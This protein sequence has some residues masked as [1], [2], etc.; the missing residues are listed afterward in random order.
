MPQLEHIGIAVNDGGDV[1]RICE[2]LEAGVFKSEAVPAEGVVTHFVSAGGPRLEFLTTTDEA[3]AV[4]RFLAK[5]GPGLHHLAFEVAGIDVLF[6]RLQSSGVELA[7]RAVTD[8]ADGKRVFFVHPRAA[9]G[10]LIE[11]CESARSVLTR[12][13]AVVGGV[14][15]ELGSD[16]RDTGGALVVVAPESDRGDVGRVVRE[17][18][19]NVPIR[20]V[21]YDESKSLDTGGGPS[22]DDLGGPPS[23]VVALGRHSGAFAIA[24]MEYSDVRVALLDPG[25]ETLA[26]VRSTP[27]AEE[28]LLVIC[29]AGVGCGGGDAVASTHWQQATLPFGGHLL[30]HELAPLVLPIIRRFFSLDREARPAVVVGKQP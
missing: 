5:R 14:P 3:S 4:G 19:P 10:V 26:R 13:T 6:E 11:F 16:S 1:A 22:F 20:T 23:Y 21:L 12:T 29:G 9:G 28:R 18:E 25:Q 2:L 30:G 24:A 15:V 17:F 27:P 7:S 8:G